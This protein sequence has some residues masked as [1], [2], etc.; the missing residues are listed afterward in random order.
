MQW[1]NRHNILM[2]AEPVRVPLY[3]SFEP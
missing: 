2:T 3:N 1:L